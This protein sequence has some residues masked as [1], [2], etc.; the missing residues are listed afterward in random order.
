MKCRVQTC[1]TYYQDNLICRQVTYVQV[2]VG[3]SNSIA[4]QFNF[5]LVSNSVGVSI[6]V[7]V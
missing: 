5:K 6:D 4:V 2:D 7:N 3:V 1:K